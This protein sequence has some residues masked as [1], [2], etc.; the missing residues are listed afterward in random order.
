MLISRTRLPPKPLKGIGRLI[1]FGG[2]KDPRY[3]ALAV[4]CVLVN[5]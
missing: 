5:L 1:D 2:F 4:G 3:S